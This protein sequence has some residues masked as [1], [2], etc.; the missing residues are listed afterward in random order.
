[1]DR[2][3]PEKV[4]SWMG[5]FSLAAL[6]LSAL[7]LPPVCQSAFG[8]GEDGRGL[9]EQWNGRRSGHIPRLRISTH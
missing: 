2:D 1:M 3:F 8:G 4:G 7:K 6:S 9:V 5:F